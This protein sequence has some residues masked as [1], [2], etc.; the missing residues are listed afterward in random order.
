[1]K[2]AEEPID[3]LSEYLARIVDPT[4]AEFQRN[5]Q[6]ARHAFLACVAIFHSVDRLTHHM[7]RANLRK[8]WRKQSI[9][10]CVVDIFAH[11]LKHVRTDD[12]KHVPN[13]PGIPLSGLVDSLD[14]H[15]LRFAMRDAIKFVRQ[16]A[17][18]LD[19]RAASRKS[20]RRTPQS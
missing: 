15:N 14:F 10:F 5:P 7:N 6:S 19:R 8:E 4:F 16:Q 18:T 1:M 13:G 17:E 12:D 2:V 3:T 11:R 9:E 20:T